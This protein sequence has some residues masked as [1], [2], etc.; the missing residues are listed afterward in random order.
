MMCCQPM[1]LRNLAPAQGIGLRGG[2][3]GTACGQRGGERLCMP[4]FFLQMLVHQRHQ[5][6]RPLH[7]HLALQGQLGG[8]LANQ[9]H[10]Q[11]QALA[12]DAGMQL[13]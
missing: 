3:C 12:G 4:L 2:P 5:P 10:P 1:P 9:I 6:R 8:L 7:R 11:Q 13:T